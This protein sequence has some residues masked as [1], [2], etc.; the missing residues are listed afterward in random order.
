MLLNGRKQY[1]SRIIYLKVK[2]DIRIFLVTSPPNPQAIYLYNMI[3]PRDEMPS[4]YFPG[5]R[6]AFHSQK[7]ILK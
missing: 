7:E 6:K 1:V 3:K 4:L 2:R 5:N